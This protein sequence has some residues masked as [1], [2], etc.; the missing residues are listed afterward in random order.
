MTF[1]VCV[2]TDTFLETFAE[3]SLEF[4]AFRPCENAKAILVIIRILTLESTTIWPMVR[5]R[6]MKL[7]VFIL[8]IISTIVSCFKFTVTAHFIIVP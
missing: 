6:A 5:A 4:P 3:V 2:A 1:Y 7:T 8:A